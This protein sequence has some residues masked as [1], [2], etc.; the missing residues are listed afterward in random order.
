M[1]EAPELAIVREVL[2]HR[3][4][5]ASVDSARVVRPTVLR[6]LVGGELDA[7]IV[8]RTVE[9]VS[10]YG[11]TL[12]LALSGDRYIVVIPM[13]AG[14]LWLSNPTDRVRKDT[15]LVLGMSL[16][17]ELRYTDD[18][19]MGMVYYA[20]GHQL[21]EIPRLE[22]TGP[23]ALDTHEDLQRFS[24]RLRRFQG[25]IKGVLTRGRLV[26]G[27]GNA[28]ADEVLF[29]AEISPFRKRAELSAAEIQ[30]LHAATHGVPAGAVDALRK[31]M[32]DDIHLKPRDFLKVH[33]KKDQTCPRCGGRISQI[34]ARHRITSYCMRCQPGLLIK[35]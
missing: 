32:K 34:T 14:R 9:S 13:L 33:N 28:Y 15:Y 22:E 11:K 20:A 25:E 24:E 10:R 7:D 21:S 27:I 29:E 23:D 1:P 30:R 3:F 16:G 8:G 35:N 18:R 31:R 19:Q 5:G 4:V 6:N 26:A 2:E 12:T 17:T